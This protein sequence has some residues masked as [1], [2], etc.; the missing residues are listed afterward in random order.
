MKVK[1]LIAVFVATVICLSSDSRKPVRGA[2]AAT[3]VVLHVI[4]EQG[5]E[6]KYSSADM[7]KLPRQSL[8][9]ADHQGAEHEFEG[10]LLAE[11][12]KASKVTL[13]K[14]LRG[15][16]LA[17]YL[18]VEARDSYRVVF[19]IPECDPDFTDRIIL[20]ADTQD[21]KPLPEGHAPLRLVIPQEKRH[22]RWVRQ[23][24]KI[25]VRSAGASGPAK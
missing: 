22:S 19:A 2:D 5:V 3:D 7:H 25:S 6:F 21:G 15:P 8:K 24:S 9:A 1:A 11:V 10:V 18:L 12:L 16:L 4:N 20:L 23:I 13:G 17:N 14:D